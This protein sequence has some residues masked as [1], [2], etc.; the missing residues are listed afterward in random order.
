MLTLTEHGCLIWGATVGEVANRGDG[1]IGGSFNFSAC[2]GL[3]ESGVPGNPPAQV[4]GAG[5]GE[6]GVG[7]TWN[8]GARYSRG[9]LRS[10][11]PMVGC[12]AIPSGCSTLWSKS[13]LELTS[14]PTSLC[15]KSG[16]SYSPSLLFSLVFFPFPFWPGLLSSLP[17]LPVF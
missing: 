4:L 9:H 17:D 2:P 12:S 8:V 5:G 13:V 10:L 15:P 14:P 16:V 6:G 7:M 11:Q 3:A 1:G